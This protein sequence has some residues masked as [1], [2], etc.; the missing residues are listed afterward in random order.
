MN[1]KKNI[2]CLIVAAG[3]G[4]RFG[5]NMPKQYTPLLGR[6]ILRWSIDTFRQ[7]PMISAVHVVIHPDHL[8]LY[9]QAAAG[10]TL[11]A[12]VPGGGTRAQSVLK[13]LESIKDADYV[14]IHDAARPCISAELI[15]AICQALLSSAGGIVPGYLLS[16]SIKRL[17]GSETASVSR[18]G[19]YAVQTPQ[20]FAYGDILR[21]H[22]GNKA[23]GITDDAGLFEKAGLPVHIIPGERKNIKVTEAEDL[24]Q[25]EE[26]LSS[27]RQDIRTGK[28][29]DV[30]RLSPAPHGLKKLVLGGIDIPHSHVL[31]GHSDADVVLHALTDALLGTICDGDIGHHFSPKD[32]QWKNADSAMFLAHAREMIAAQG[33]IISHAD[34]TVICEEPRIG[35]HREKMRERIAHILQLPKSRVSVK[36][37]TSEGLGFTGRREGIAAE[38]VATVRLPFGSPSANIIGLAT[39]L[40]QEA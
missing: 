31:E 39:P 28:G 34:L 2:V 30:H 5:G 20:A 1:N 23:P 4:Q 37:T 24:A 15:T 38:A 32:Q 27:A 19:L 3:T 16:D 22:R 14:L 18:D 8:D 17:S 29:Y 11:P 12:A 10:V 36:A 21:L 40:K 35:P 26:I 9:Q 25:A 13:G 7:H 6:P 33:G